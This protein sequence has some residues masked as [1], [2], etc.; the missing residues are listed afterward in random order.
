MKKKSLIF[1][2]LIGYC[3]KIFS[4]LIIILGITLV[5]VNIVQIILRGFFKS[6]FLWILEFSVFLGIWIVLFGASV[7][8][9]RDTEVKV[10]TIVNY[11]PKI[12]R[13]VIE[14]FVSILGFIFAI[15]LIWGNI[16]YQ[17]YVGIIKPQYLFFSFRVHTFPVYILG[18][19]IIYNC[20][21]VIFKKNEENNK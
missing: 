15:F 19:T 10:E 9:L 5:G 18:I 1:D 3:D 16:N 17:K 8:F 7:M 2:K 6:S 21:N 20:L 14:I 12:A 11:F 13:R 4:S